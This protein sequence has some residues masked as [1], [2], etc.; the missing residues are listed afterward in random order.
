MLQAATSFHHAHSSMHGLHK[1]T[2][3]SCISLHWR[4]A[5]NCKLPNPFIECTQ[6]GV[7]FVQ[8]QVP[9]LTFSFD[10]KLSYPWTYAHSNIIAYTK[11]QHSAAT[12]F[13]DVPLRVASC[14]LPSM[15]TLKLVLHSQSHSLH[16]SLSLS[17]SWLILWSLSLL[18]SMS[19]SLSLSLSGVVVRCPLAL[20]R[21]PLAIVRCP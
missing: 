7:A 8:L 20:V 3:F 15:R 16:I 17:L 10:C 12:P 21:R 13:I 6:A 18:L 1:A 4:A 14:Q 2:A 11:P 9:S 5:S 19:L